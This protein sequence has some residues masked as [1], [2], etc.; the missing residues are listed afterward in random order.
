MAELPD[1]DTGREYH[2]RQLQRHCRVCSHP[3][4]DKAYRYR[5]AAQTEAFWEGID[6]AIANDSADIHPPSLCNN[7]FSKIQQK[8][9][10]VEV[11]KWEP[12]TA[13]ICTVCELF[14]SQSAGGRPKKERKNRG[15]PKTNTLSKAIQNIAEQARFSWGSSKPLELSR[16]L[17][18]AADLA[19]DDFACQLCKCILD[20]P[21]QMRCGKLVCL[22]CL[23]QFWQKS[24]MEAAE[25]YPCPS[26]DAGYH[27]L[28][29]TAAA[30]VISK[31]IG[32]LLLHCYICR[33][34]VR[35]EH[36]STHLQSNCTERS[37]APS[38]SRLTVGQILCRPANAPP[39]TAEKRVA[40]SVVKRLLHTSASEVVSLPTAGQVYTC[41]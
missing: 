10:L 17:P 15:R 37:T 11:Y 22:A 39:T 26:C 35:L 24:G 31:V 41:I 9:G 40:T 13:P 8:K 1:V 23:D 4:K 6:I 12:H 5:C 33:E 36:L 16:F 27:D 14:Q 38:P 2:L 20:R 19:L 21:V 7:C 32:S 30:D 25:T 28:V 3:F 18:P 29:P 34:V